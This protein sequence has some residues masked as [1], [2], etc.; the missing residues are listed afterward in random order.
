MELSITSLTR[1][2]KPFSSVGPIYIPGC[3]RTG[4]DTL[5]AEV[6]QNGHRYRQVYHCGI[7]EEPLKIVGDTEETGTT[8]TFH[9]DAT[10]LETTEFNYD[11]LKTLLREL[12]YLN[13]GKQAL[14]RLF[15]YR[16]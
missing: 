3:S 6:C 7:P 8:I 16:S 10:I 14:R 13:K 2:C 4:S 12:S 5:T 9:P 11:T 15:P 1:Q